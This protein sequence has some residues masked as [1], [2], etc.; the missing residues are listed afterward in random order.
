MPEAVPPGCAG[1]TA[2]GAIALPDDPGWIVD[3]VSEM[4]APRR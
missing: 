2:S 4:R 1:I 3:L